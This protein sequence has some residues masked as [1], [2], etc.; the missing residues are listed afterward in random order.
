MHVYLDKRE[1][2][3]N[4]NMP[5]DVLKALSSY[6]ELAGDKLM[7]HFLNG[8]DNGEKTTMTWDNHRWVRCRSTM[9]LVETFLAD[10]AYSVEHPEPGDRTFFE[11]IGRD[12]DAPPASYPITEEQRKEAM[13][14]T[15]RLIMLGHKDGALKDGAPKP[16]PALRIRPSF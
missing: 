5:A 13:K 15:E 8:V 1:G 14:M 2:G 16:T 10:F 4:L 7:D 6:G 11:L 12:R 9:A 3:L